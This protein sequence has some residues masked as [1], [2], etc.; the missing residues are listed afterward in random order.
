MIPNFLNRASK[1]YGVPWSFGKGK[2]PKKRWCFLLRM[3]ISQY[4]KVEM[5]KKKRVGQDSGTTYLYIYISCFY[6]CVLLLPEVVLGRLC[7]FWWIPDFSNSPGNLQAAEEEPNDWVEASL[8]PVVCEGLVDACWEVWTMRR[9]TVGKLW[10]LILLSFSSLKW[11]KHIFWR[12][13][14]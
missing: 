12:G 9:P 14:F 11:D 8:M 4:I 6:M 7:C 3:L 2:L 10:V 5:E 13:C 1:P